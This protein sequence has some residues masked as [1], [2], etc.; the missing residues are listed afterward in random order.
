[1]NPQNIAKQIP[2]IEP[3]NHT[4]KLINIQ[5]IAK[6]GY[7]ERHNFI[8]GNFIIKFDTQSLANNRIFATKIKY[9][10]SK[11]KHYISGIMVMRNGKE[12][13]F[14]IYDCR[15]YNIKIWEVINGSNNQ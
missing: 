6:N 2:V 9:I 1:M 7:F 5:E 12:G 11:N 8:V 10:E 13:P 4:H 14:I 15:R 3:T